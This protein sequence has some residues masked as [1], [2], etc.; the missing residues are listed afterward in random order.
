MAFANRLTSKKMLAGH[1]L[2]RN[3][4]LGPLGLV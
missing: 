1:K 3:A 2:S 4:W